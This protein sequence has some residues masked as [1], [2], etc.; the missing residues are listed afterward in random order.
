[1]T[2]WLLADLLARGDVARVACVAPTG[3]PG[4]LFRAAVFTDPEDVRRSAKSAYYPVEFSDALREIAAGDGPAALV[5]LPCVLKAARLAMRRDRRLRERLVFLVGL[6]CGQSKSRGFTEYLVSRLGLDP[7]Q[8]R[9][10]GFREK[11]PD[12]PATNFNLAAETPERRATCPWEGEY[13]RAWTQ[14]LFKPRPCE[15]CDDTFAEVADVCLMDAWL[16]AYQQDSHGTSLLLT[17][18]VLAQAAVERGI[19]EGALALAPIAVEDV[20]RSQAGVVW[21]KREQ[22]AYRLWL[23]DRDGAPRPQKRVQPAQPPLGQTGVLRAKEVL[24]AASHA[25]WQAA[26]GQADAVARFTAA[27]QGPF[28]RLKWRS[29]LA[30]LAAKLKIDRRRRGRTDVDAHPAFQ[31]GPAA[32]RGRGDADIDRSFK[33]QGNPP[34]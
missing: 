13:N 14:G 25:A 32:A 16:P 6:V 31:R 19:A 15:F 27:M 20:V 34:K 22:L 8:V 11:A 9:K 3:E 33:K 17:R 24:R 1:M 23:A 4:R 29:K 30:S 2:S 26:R 21:H 12:R 7:A 5:G 18:S 28:A 10:V